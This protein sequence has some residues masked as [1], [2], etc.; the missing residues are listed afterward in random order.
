M[1]RRAQAVLGHHRGASIQ[2]LATLFAVGYNTVSDW[3]RRWQTR[4]LAGL[5]E[6]PRRGRP[7]KLLPVVKKSSGLV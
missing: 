1:R 7:T 3:R 2:A 5:A 4:G 6:G